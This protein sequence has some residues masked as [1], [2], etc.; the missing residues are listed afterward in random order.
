MCLAPPALS[1]VQRRRQALRRTDL[2]DDGTCRPGAQHSAVQA[3]GRTEEA[4]A[5]ASTSSSE[6]RA[7]K[8]VTMHGGSGHAPRNSTYKGR[9]A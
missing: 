3:Q 1:S 8:A 4:R 7:Q 6:P 9:T 5:R 2:L